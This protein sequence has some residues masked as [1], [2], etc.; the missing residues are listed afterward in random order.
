M[1]EKLLGS[2]RKIAPEE[3]V[4]TSLGD[5]EPLRFRSETECR[6]FF[7]NK[8]GNVS[9]QTQLVRFEPMNLRGVEGWNALR[10]V[11]VPS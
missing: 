8:V 10:V 2:Y 5:P 6:N 4:C 9:N 11:T 1:A 3:F 7:K